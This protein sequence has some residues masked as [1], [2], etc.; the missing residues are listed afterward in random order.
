MKAVR[1]VVQDE[2][3][4]NFLDR[5]D[6]N[7]GIAALGRFGLT[8]DLLIFARQLPKAIDFVDRHPQ[9][10]FVLD[11]MAKPLI[12]QGELEPWAT[13]VRELARRENVVCK[14]S[15]LATQAEASG[16][17]LATLRPY[18]DVVLESFGPRRL[19]FGSDWP[20]CLLATSYGRWNETIRLW[21][22]TLTNDERAWFLGRTAMAA[23][24]IRPEPQPMH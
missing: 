10:P 2:P 1:H 14:I 9:Q 19:M 7:A 15:G 8:Y 13:H 3:D 17:S 20:V 6:F 4:E 5:P 23:Y 24:H 18:L 21:A 12:A 16:W 11:H 22:E